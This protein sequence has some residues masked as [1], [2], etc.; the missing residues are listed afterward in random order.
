MQTL[1]RMRIR[2]PEQVSVLGFDNL[3]ISEIAYPPLT[4]LAQDITQK[5]FLVVDM[6]VRHIRQKTIPPEH[7]LLGVWLVE[8][9]SVRKM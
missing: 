4:T 9:D 3:P 2:I 6:L 1:H 7:T 5:A 8:R